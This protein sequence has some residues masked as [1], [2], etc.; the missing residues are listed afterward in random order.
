MSSDIHQ[1]GIDSWSVEDKLRLIGEIW[2]SLEA[3]PTEIPEAHRE[4]LDR[5]LDAADAEP[6]AGSPAHE[7]MAR[8]RSRQ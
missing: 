2:D 3:A 6:D 5:R 4:E 7:V 8:L 1:L